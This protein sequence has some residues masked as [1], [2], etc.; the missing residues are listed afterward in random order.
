MP[1]SLPRASRW[2][3]VALAVG[4]GLGFVP[5]RRTDDHVQ[6]QKEKENIKS[7]GK[8]LE[9]IT[10][11]QL[12]K[13]KP[14]LPK[15]EKAMETV[16]ELGQKLQKNKFTRAQALADLANVTDK[17]KN[18]TDQMRKN[19]GIKKLQKAAR[20]SGGERMPSAEEIEKQIESMQRELEGKDIDGKMTKALEKMKR[21]LKKLKEAAA[22]MSQ[23]GSAADGKASQEMS[24]ALDELMQQAEDSRHRSRRSRRGGRS[25]Q[26]RRYRQVS[27]GRRCRADRLGENAA[28]CAQDE[29]IEKATGRGRQRSAG[30][31]RKGAGPAGDRTIAEIGP[32]AQI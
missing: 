19:P 20:E 27:E 11:R 13:R 5:E 9:D 12:K 10:K 25:P 2:V 16:A 1:F 23:N 3:L 21:E 18:E 31:A 6:R 15:T 17:L 26:P 4:A 29:R 30:A 7:T 24:D 32:P 14:A 8:H 28:V 22:S